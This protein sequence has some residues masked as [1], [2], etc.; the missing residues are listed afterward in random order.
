MK[1]E[2]WPEFHERTRPMDATFVT[3]RIDG[4]S[5][6]ITGIECNSRPGFEQTAAKQVANA[7]LDA[8]IA[9]SL[10]HHEMGVLLKQLGQILQDAKDP[11]P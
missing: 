8:F 2:N 10:S 5:A 3:I 9:G 1:N 7:A 11:R 4:I 6:L